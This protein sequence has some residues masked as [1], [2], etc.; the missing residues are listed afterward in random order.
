LVKLINGGFSGLTKCVAILMVEVV[1]MFLN[2]KGFSNEMGGVIR[3]WGENTKG[4]LYKLR[5]K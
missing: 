5:K 3:R 1:R 2:F 4:M